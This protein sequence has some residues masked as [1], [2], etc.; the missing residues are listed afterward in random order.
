MALSKKNF[1]FL[2][3]GCAKNLVEGEHLAGMLIDGGYRFTSHISQADWLLVNTCGFLTSAIEENIDHI[4]DLASRKKNS[5][6]LVVIGCL[7]GRFGKKLKTSLPEVDLFVSPGQ[8]ANLLELMAA[9]PESAMAFSPAT[10]LLNSPR[11]LS[12]GPSWAYLRLGDGCLHNCSFCAIPHIRGKLRSRALPDLVN[13][14]RSLAQ[15]G[16]KELNLVAQDVSSYG[17]D[18]NMT[19]GLLGLLREL[20]KIDNLQW[21]RLLYLYPDIITEEFLRE[22][23]SFNRVLPYFDIPLQHIADP[24]LKA[25]GRPHS[26]AGLRHNL[27]LIRRII[28]QAVVRTTFLVGHPGEG[29]EEFNNLLQFVEEFKF[30]RLGCFAFEPQQGTRSYLM[31]QIPARI[32]RARQKKLMALQKKISRQLLRQLKGSCQPML[33][34]GEHPESPLLG[35]GRLWSQ[36]PEA[37]GEVI[38]VDGG[39]R[40]GDIVSAKILKTH[41]YDLEATLCVASQQL[42][43]NCPLPPGTNI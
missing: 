2:N 9:I 23:N 43:R 4:L 41:A 17:Q 6:K 32:A 14:A 22:I 20:D 29:E 28:P 34:L 3:L 25:M 38:V 42:L 12:T 30:D 21:I 1:Y 27:G 33:F 39:A 10:G 24:V 35:I 40:P 19:H 13:E 36:A 31:P 5:Q 15:S 26:E 7:V 18:L 8:A 11:A 37:D 16:I